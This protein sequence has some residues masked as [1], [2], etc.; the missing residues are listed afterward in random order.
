LSPAEEAKAPAAPEVPAVAT[1]SSVATQPGGPPATPARDAG[2]GPVADPLELAQR[3]SRNDPLDPA[4]R[5]AAQM[6]PLFQAPPPAPAVSTAAPVEAETRASLESML[7]EL[8]RK[9]AWSGDGKKGSMRLELGAGAL[10]GGTLLVH[11]D[12]GRVRVELNAPAGTDVDAW[13]ARLQE[14][15]DRRG[16]AVDEIIVE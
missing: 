5:H 9:I 3:R 2:D 12:E 14:R 8:V 10:A 11:A 6:A 13:K 7:P 1:T 16:V 15:L 4:A